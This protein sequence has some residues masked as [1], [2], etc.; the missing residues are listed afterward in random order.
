MDTLI[1]GD[2][3][4]AEHLAFQAAERPHTDANGALACLGVTLVN[5]RLLQR[6]SGEVLDLLTAA[7]DDHPEVPCYRAVLALCAAEAGESVRAAAAY[8]PFRRSRFETVPNDTNRLLTLAVLAD[9]TIAV[10]DMAAAHDL[11]ALLE[12]YRAEHAVL[13]CYGGGGAYWGPV[14]GQLAGLAAL[15]GLDDEA[16]RLAEQAHRSASAVAC[17]LVFARLGEITRPA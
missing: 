6:R 16:A 8:E 4:R 5:V 9:V 17:P 15:T 7:A 14:A 10:G 2:L 13:N 11:W 3:E 12:P 1:S